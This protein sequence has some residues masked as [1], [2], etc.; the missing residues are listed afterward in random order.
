MHRLVVAISVALVLALGAPARAIEAVEISPAIAAKIDA[1]LEAVTGTS[2]GQSPALSVAVL[3]HGKIVYARAFGVSDLAAKIPAT[4]HTRFRIGS[5]TKM[6]TAVSIMQLVEAGRLKLDAP[7]AA[8]LPDAPH[9]SEV[10]IRQ[11]LMHRSGIWNYGDAAFS[12]PHVAEPIAPAEIVELARSHPLDN[13][14]GT[15]FS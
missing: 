13:L 5:V 3:E 9:A 7:L 10:T 1:A 14:P 15:S 12:N 8:Y 4:P 6:F 2:S 11:L